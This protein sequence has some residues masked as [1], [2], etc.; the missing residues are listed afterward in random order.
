MIVQFRVLPL[1]HVLEDTRVNIGKGK[2]ILIQTQ[3]QITLVQSQVREHPEGI[4]LGVTDDQ[5]IA[6]HKVDSLRVA[7]RGKVIGY[8]FQNI[9]EDF[10]F[11]LLEFKGSIEVFF[12][13]REAL[14]VLC[15]GF[16]LVVG[17]ILHEAGIISQFLRIRYLLFFISNLKTKAFFV[18]FVI[19][20]Q[21]VQYNP[22]F[23]HDKR[24]DLLVSAHALAYFQDVLV[25]GRLQ[26]LRELEKSV[27]GEE[28]VTY[29]NFGI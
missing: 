27:M 18:L 23:L 19:F 25:V 29:F 24:F 1:Q 14:M 21:S 6:Y 11:F 3:Y 10:L 26:D 7:H 4:G 15:A 28:G 22:P 8:S 13:L 12:Y 5:Q 9:F 16:E 2:A 20:I 17:F